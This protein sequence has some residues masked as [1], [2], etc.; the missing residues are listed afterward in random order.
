MAKKTDNSNLSAKLG[1]RRYFL[2][3][4][5]ADGDIRVLDCCQGQGVLWN[6]LRQEFD[7]ASYW[8]TDI[9]QKKGRLKL[10]SARILSQPGWRENVID[11]DTYG[12]PWK[13][14]REVLANTTSPTTVFL[15]RGSHSLQI[16]NGYERSILGLEFSS[17][18]P[19][20]L[21]P[22]LRLIDMAIRY[23]V[24]TVC[25]GIIVTEA[26]EAVSAGTARYVGVRLEK[27]TATQVE[28]AKPS[29]HRKPI[30]EVCNV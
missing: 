8:G 5:H 3:K 6:T 7:V 26:V 22:K 17:P 11:I 16:L 12:S 15:T 25:D 2:R 4:Y 9:K 13:H 19:D 14:W 1:L 30:K 29:E 10:D 23:C 28:T 20:A 21:W 27:A 18:I 24:A